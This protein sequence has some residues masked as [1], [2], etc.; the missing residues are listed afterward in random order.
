MK[1][2]VQK[3]LILSGCLLA[4][5][6]FADSANA[7]SCSPSPTVDKEFVASSNVVVLKLVSVKDAEKLNDS[8]FAKERYFLT[9]EKVFKGNLKIGETLT[10]EPGF[11]CTWTFGKEDVGGDYLF[12]LD[13][14]PQNINS[15]LAGFCSRSGTLSGRTS[16]LL[17][18]E[19]EKQMRGKTRLSGTL[20]KMIQIPEKDGSYVFQSLANRKIKIIGK[21]KNVELITD[22]NGDYEIY[23]LPVGKYKIFPE[24]VSGYTFSSWKEEF[25]EVEIK[26]KS[27]TEKNFYFEIDNAVS[28]KVIDAFGKPLKNVCLDL[29]PSIKEKAKNYSKGSC[30]NEKGEF[31]ISSIPEGSYYLAINKDGEIRLYEPFKTFYYPNVKNREEATEITIREN[32]F[33][34]DLRITPPEMIETVTISGVLLY[35]NGEPVID[36]NVKFISEKEIFRTFDGKVGSDDENYTDEKGR[37]SFTI[38]KGQSGILRS[39]MFSFIGKYK[40]CPE[41][42]NLVRQK[43]DSVQQIDTID[44]NVDATESLSNIQLKFPFSKCEEAKDEDE[45]N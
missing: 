35:K 44:V 34:K 16:D 9:V 14:R 15:W 24:K 32:T 25:E 30:T 19:K 27:H 6:I 17:Y 36:Q 23:N 8:D 39:S 38:W 28:G 21:E 45:D 11:A 42:D 3:L 29:I 13:E 26:A 1:I 22:G 5:I 18:F 31:E 43:G 4:L 33:L 20:N 7:C 37:F 2:L 41:I 10:F 12:Y 40:N